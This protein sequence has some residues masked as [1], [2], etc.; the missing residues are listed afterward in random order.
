MD[1]EIAMT[2]GFWLLPSRRRIDKL[3]AFFKTAAD[4]G[5][6]TIGIVLVERREMEELWSEY[7]KLILPYGWSVTAVEAE[8]MAAKVAEGYRRFVG[9]ETKWAGV[10]S[11]D[12]VPETAGWDTALISRLN[13]WNIITSDDCDQ[14]PKRMEGATVWSRE[15]VDA[16]GFMAPPG[17]NHLFF[18]NCWEDIGKATNCLQWAMDVKVRHAHSGITK[19]T[20]TTSEKVR[21]F[22]DADEKT[23]RDW[24]TAELKNAVSRVFT[25]MENKGVKVSR[26]DLTG[27]SIMLATPSA[28]GHFDR[29]YLRSYEQSVAAIRSAGGQL[30]LAEMPFCADL[31][32]ARSK[33]FGAFLR[34]SHTHMLF[35]DDDMGW[36]A[37]DILRMVDSGYELVGGAGPKKKYPMQFCVSER[38]ADGSN[39]PTLYNEADGSIE[40]AALGTGFLLMRKSCAERMAQAYPE[41]KFDPGEGQSDYALFDPL[42]VGSTRFSDDFAFCHR[43]RAIGGKV[44]C[45]PIIHL[46]HSGNHVFQ[47]SLLQTMMGA[48]QE[49]RSAA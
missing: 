28:Q 1:G 46:K 26:P 48:A 2:D 19:L 49:V 25:L 43:W 31:G 20:D 32:L 33:L 38:A 5:M 30:H 6:T 12:M 40:V 22:W 7:G 47:G 44:Y 3:R 14:A 10:L 45:L 16:V 15:L 29:E 39:V 18:D 24:S 27:V 23:Y 13:G 37:G 11:D 4:T 41:L 8:G 9:D 34:S 21:S 36:S 42:I 17:L 35:V